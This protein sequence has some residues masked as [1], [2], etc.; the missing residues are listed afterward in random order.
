MQDHRSRIVYPEFAGRHLQQPQI[1]TP[2]IAEK[3]TNWHSNEIFRGTAQISSN[4]ADRC[5]RQI[6]LLEII[7]IVGQA[8]SIYNSSLTLMTS[9]ADTTVSG[10]NRGL[11]SSN[12]NSQDSVT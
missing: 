6:Q 11:G 8:R 9:F 10:T 2:S 1:G 5:H 12:R 4:L 7:Y 3:H